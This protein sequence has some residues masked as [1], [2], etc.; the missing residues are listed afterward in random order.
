MIVKRPNRTIIYP[1]SDGMATAA[2]FLRDKESII[3]LLKA[4][5]A[6][7]IPLF[8]IREKHLGKELLTKLVTEAVAATQNSATRV[9][10]NGEVEVA[11]DCGA[12]GVHLPSSG[13]SVREVRQVVGDDRLIAVSTHS[14]DDINRAKA[15]GADLVV[16]GPVFDT[17][18]KGE[19]KGIDALRSACQAAGEM[20]VVAL[21]GITQENVDEVL[22]SGAAGFAAIRYLNDKENLKK[23]GEWLRNDR[24]DVS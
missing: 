11:V 15:D 4:A 6:A 10:V 14:L 17:P 9:L 19:P 23:L 22:D 20:P 1:I 2:G 12:D 18:G 7:C 3:G 24:R 5:A 21:G 13:Y 8:Q 16:F